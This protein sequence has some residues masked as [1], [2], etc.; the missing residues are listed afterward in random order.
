MLCVQ[1]GRVLHQYEDRG[2]IQGYASALS[3][4]TVRS[5]RVEVLVQG[6]FYEIDKCVPN[7]SDK[8]GPWPAYVCSVITDR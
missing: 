3:D 2:S 6:K 4:R 5:D 8:P 1:I 7:G